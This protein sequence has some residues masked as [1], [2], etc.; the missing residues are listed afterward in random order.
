[1][2]SR[3]GRAIAAGIVLAALAA[4]GFWLAGKRN[5][6]RPATPVV[7][8]PRQEVELRDGQL[9]RK[10]DGAIFS[11]V[12]FEQAAGGRRITEVPVK[13]GR[14]HGIARGWHDNGQLEVEEPFE[15]GVSHGV[16]TRWHPNGQKRNEATIV[17]G[18]LE[19][20][21]TE[22]HDNGQL[23]TRMTL[24]AGKGEGVCET[25]DPDGRL[26]SRVTLRNGA[27]M[28]NEVASRSA[29]PSPAKPPR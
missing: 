8:V 25:W 16:R 6:G 23:A 22:W 4:G 7:E 2:W 18:L 5:A 24:A 12:M 10:A 17:R 3:T 11:G 27:P 1:M 14:V 28:E 20:P 21:F 29:E 9:V 26:K 19:G 15:D 13:D